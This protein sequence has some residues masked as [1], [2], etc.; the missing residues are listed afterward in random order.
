MLH[1][2]INRNVIDFKL[3]AR[4]KL[5]FLLKGFLCCEFFQQIPKHFFDFLVFSTPVLLWAPSSVSK[6]NDKKNATWKGKKIMLYKCTCTKS[7]KK[8]FHVFKKLQL[9]TMKGER[10]H[11]FLVCLCFS[12]L[13]FFSS[14]INF[15]V[16]FHCLPCIKMREWNFKSSQQKS[17]LIF[18]QF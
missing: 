7:R 4:V 16:H 3:P 9:A 8:Y 11:F 18:M 10:I 12:L 1:I 13:F 5:V 2:L 14:R 15:K 17:S 6:R